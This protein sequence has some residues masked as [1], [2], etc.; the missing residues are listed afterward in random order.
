MGV[1]LALPLKEL[2]PGLPWGGGGGGGGG[3]EG[4]A[5]RNS[6]TVDLYNQATFLLQPA[7]HGPKEVI[8][9]PPPS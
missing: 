4:G 8:P 9:V 5:Q 6:Y 1:A 2:A 3:G 7:A